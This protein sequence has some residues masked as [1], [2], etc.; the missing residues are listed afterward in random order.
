MSDQWSYVGVF[1]CGSEGTGL[2]DCFMEFS[3]EIQ[4]MGWLMERDEGKQG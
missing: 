2:S 3:L 4:R 1:Q